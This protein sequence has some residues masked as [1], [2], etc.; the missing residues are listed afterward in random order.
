MGRVEKPEKGRGI[1]TPLL[2]DN[3]GI[4][5]ATDAVLKKV[6]EKNPWTTD[7]K[8]VSR[9][10]CVVSNDLGILQKKKKFIL[11][12]SEKHKARNFLTGLRFRRGVRQEKGGERVR[13]NEGCIV[14]RTK[15]S[16]GE[17]L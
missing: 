4:R 14:L 3:R 2:R 11:A 8:E 9:C 1:K 10:S 13:C 6:M 5:G 16:E 7:M 17:R 12:R 15:S